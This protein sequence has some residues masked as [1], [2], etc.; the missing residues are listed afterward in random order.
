MLLSAVVPSAARWPVGDCVGMAG[1]LLTGS[2]V[3]ALRRARTPI[4]PHR[5]PAA[6]VTTGPY[7]FTR[8][9][10]YLG[11]ALIYSARW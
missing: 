3:Y 2:F 10:G 8:N 7:R 11:M 1:I 5:A 4:V 9:P 6:Q